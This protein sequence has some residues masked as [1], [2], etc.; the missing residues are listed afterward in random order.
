MAGDEANGDA[1]SGVTRDGPLTVSGTVQG[2]PES[3]RG[4]ACDDIASTSCCLLLRYWNRSDSHQKRCSDIPG[5]VYIRELRDCV[6]S[7]HHRDPP[8]A[9]AVWRDGYAGLTGISSRRSATDASARIHC[10]FSLSRFLAVCVALCSL[11]LA[12]T[13][14]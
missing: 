7:S 13:S 12:D 3:H 8:G 14:P 10:A 2:C 1:P 11:A 5:A 6:H 4:P 9:F